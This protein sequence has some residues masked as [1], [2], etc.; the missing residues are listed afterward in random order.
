MQT[1]IEAKACKTD[2]KS[3]DKQGLLRSA[4]RIWLLQ[5]SKLKS[6]RP[7]TYAKDIKS[8]IVGLGKRCVVE[9]TTTGYA[10][11]VSLPALK[12]AIEA[13]GP[14]HRC[15]NSKQALGATVMKQRHLKAAGWQLITVAHDDWDLLSGREQK[16]QFLRTEIERCQAQIESSC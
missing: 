11:D 6:Q 5:I 3:H 13:D 9:D 2:I 10:V 4:K 1:S 16:L 8:V 15:R 12:I 7:S 14:T